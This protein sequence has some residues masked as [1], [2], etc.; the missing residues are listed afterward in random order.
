MISGPAV[1]WKAPGEGPFASTHGSE[2]PR[3]G[4]RQGAC[5]PSLFP[6]PG[7]HLP[8][9][10]PAAPLGRWL[11]PRGGP[12]LLQPGSQMEKN[13]SSWLKG[14]L[15]PRPPSQRLG[16]G[17]TWLRLPHSGEHSP[18]ELGRSQFCP[19]PKGSCA[20]TPEIKAG[21]CWAPADSLYETKWQKPLPLPALCSSGN[22]GTLLPTPRVPGV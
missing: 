2:E 21:A 8:Q 18:Q 14:C 20:S 7:S 9:A 17:R 19:H 11:R 4:K 5:H 16:P 22:A 10:P 15:L 1:S 12:A 3:A 13:A 6:A